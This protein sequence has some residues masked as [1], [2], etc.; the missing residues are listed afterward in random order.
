MKNGRF[1]VPGTKTGYGRISQP[2]RSAN[3]G[4]HTAN[5]ADQTAKQI[6]QAKQIKIK[7]AE[8]TQIQTEVSLKL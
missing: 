8:L 1:Q 6:K 5:L 3:Q 2:R 7:D 4:D